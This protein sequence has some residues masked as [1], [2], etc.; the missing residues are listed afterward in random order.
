MNELVFLDPDKIDSEPFT[1]SKLVAEHGKVDHHALQVMISKYEE[2]LKEFGVLS[3]EMSKPIQQ[4]IDLKSNPENT[5]ISNRRNQGGR[6]EKIYHLNEQQATLL[7]TYMKNTLPVRKFKK[8]LVK[9][10]YIM[11]KELNKRAITREKAKEAREALTNAIQKL[12]ESPHKAMKYKHFTDLVYKIVF[13]MNCK[14]LKEQYGIV[15]KES[16]R[17]YFKADE[18]K[19]VEE[20]EKQVSVLIDLDYDYQTIKALLNKKYLLTA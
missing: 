7:I 8:A 15:G 11:Q 19:R 14:Q 6:P 9:Q 17:D 1:T 10:F 18:L 16:V 5:S 4:G 20:I 12:P 3:F 2:D 13:N